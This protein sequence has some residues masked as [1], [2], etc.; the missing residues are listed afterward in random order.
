MPAV[1]AAGGGAHAEATLSKVETV[2]DGA[3]DAIV[4]NPANERMIDAAIQDK[5]LN[6]PADWIVGEGGGDG[7]AHAEAA[8]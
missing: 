4:W 3:T 6:E 7:D 1:G 2:A 8:A 5:I